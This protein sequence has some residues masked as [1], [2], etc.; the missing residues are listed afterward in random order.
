MRNGMAMNARIINPQSP[1]NPQ[2][3]ILNPQCHEPLRSGNAKTYSALPFSGWRTSGLMIRGTF[4]G[5]PPPRP[6][7]TAM[8]CRPA[9]LNVTGEP[10]TE[11]PSRVSH[12]VSPVFTSKA[13]NVRPKSPT[14]PMPL[15]VVNTDVR[16][17]A[18]CSRDHTSFIVFTSYA[19]SLP[20]WPSLPGISKN[21]RSAPAPPEPSLNSIFRPD[22]SMHD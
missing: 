16:N 10:C 18:R 1:I 2:S 22:L 17:D 8:Y 21:L 13:R 20:T 4:L 6:V 3:A 14:K 15:A 7:V 9:M 12:N 19:A 5:L 11:V